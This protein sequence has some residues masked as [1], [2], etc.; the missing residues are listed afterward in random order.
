VLSTGRVCAGK[1]SCSTSCSH[2]WACGWVC[3]QDLVTRGWRGWA[4]SEEAECPA[5]M[6]GLEASATPSAPC[7][8][9]LTEAGA[10][11]E[12]ALS[13]F[14][15]ASPLARRQLEGLGIQ[16]PVRAEWKWDWHPRPSYPPG[17]TSFLWSRWRGAG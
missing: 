11:R 16:A 13:F 14:S 5:A 10:V 4:G 6:G 15:G 9:P 1:A 2:R 7:S 12:S 17:R 3:P 8:H